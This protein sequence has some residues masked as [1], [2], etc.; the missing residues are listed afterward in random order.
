MAA[1]AAMVTIGVFATAM[2]IFYF[3]ESL[4]LSVACD[5]S[6]VIQARQIV[7]NVNYLLAI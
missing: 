1:F 4:Y 6:G 5:F 3:D 7:N 2:P